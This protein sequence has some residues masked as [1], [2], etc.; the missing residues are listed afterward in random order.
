MDLQVLAELSDSDLLAR[1]KRLAQAECRATAA[2]I[3]HLIEVENRKLYLGE[4]CGSLFAYC[5]RV[6]HYSEPAAYNRIL[7]ARAARAFPAVL[8]HLERGDVHLAAVRLLAPVLTAENQHELLAAAAHKSKREVEELVVR[9]RPQEDARESVRKLPVAARPVSVPQ[10]LL[11][12]DANDMAG[13][14]ACGLFASPQAQAE[15]G[16][17]AAARAPMQLPAGEKSQGHTPRDSQPHAQRAE[18][19]PLAPERYKIQCTVGAATRDNLRR[20]QELLRHRIPGGDVSEVIDLAL[21]MLVRDLEKKKFAALAPS[22]AKATAKATVTAT[23]TAPEV[24]A[25][26]AASGSRYVPAEVRRAVWQRDQGR[27]VFTAANGARCEERSGLEFD[28]IQPYADG[29]GVEAANIRLL[30]RQHNQ[31]AARQFFGPW[32]ADG[33][34]IP[35]CG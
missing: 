8:S 4:A 9:I 10:S 21:E 19:V 14:P 3:A 25:A 17:D 20:A 5:V 18:V 34:P 13:S 30:C 24:T 28:H 2:L 27:C 16:A 26:A 33:E 22:K 11:L 23:V 15:A 12:A 32:R 31:Y 6:L 29:G 1:V 35:R 7:A